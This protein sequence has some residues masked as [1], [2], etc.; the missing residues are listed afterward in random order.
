MFSSQ[1]CVN[2]NSLSNYLRHIGEVRFL[3]L[4]VCNR[5]SSHLNVGAVDIPLFLCLF[6][7]LL[8]LI[9]PA[10]LSVRLVGFCMAMACVYGLG[11]S[12]FS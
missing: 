5:L 10:P 9:V 7:S 3:F 6:F 4:I 8:I 11:G 12:E 2:G 1:L